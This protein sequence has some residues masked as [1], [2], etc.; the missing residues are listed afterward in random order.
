M[1]LYKINKTLW[2]GI[3]LLKIIKKKEF[4]NTRSMGNHESSPPTYPT[5][6]VYPSCWFFI[7]KLLNYNK[8]KINNNI[9]LWNGF[10][11][12]FKET[13]SSNPLPYTVRRY[14]CINYNFLY[15]FYWVVCACVDTKQTWAAG[16][17]YTL[18]G[19]QHAIRLPFP[20]P[21]PAAV[22]FYTG[23]LIFY[24]N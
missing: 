13:A 7:G 6:P 23:R 21:T 10:R 16:V 15:V 19:E 18:R 20:L 8:K 9:N 1:R 24:I 5:K 3:T 22:V 14:T 17:A 11:E 2:E 4:K 12:E